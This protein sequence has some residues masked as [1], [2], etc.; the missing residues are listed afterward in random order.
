MNWPTQNRHNIDKCQN[1]KKEKREGRRGTPRQTRK[2]RKKP[3]KENGHEQ[4][5]GTKARERRIERQRLR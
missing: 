3:M 4:Q 5:V 1:G 2:C